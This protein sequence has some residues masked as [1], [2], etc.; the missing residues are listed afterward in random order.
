M[1][2]TVDDLLEAGR[3]A[4][5]RGDWAQARAVLSGAL[6]RQE[7]P[8]ILYYLARAVE[9]S[10][11]YRAAV[12]FYERAFTAYRARGEA[13]MPALIAGRELSFLHAAVYGN[14][15]VAAGWL[16]RA[17]GLAGEA[18]D[19]VERGWVR[20]A[21][22]LVTDDPA[23]KAAHVRDAAE[24]ADR[25][26]DADLRFCALGNQGVT[27]VLA[28]RIT[29]GMRLLDE[30]ATAATSGEVAD[31][32]TAGEIYCHMLTC[33]ELAFD[34]RRAQ[35]WIT[36]GTEFGDRANAPWVSAICRTHY[37]GIL[38]AAGRW[39][40][41][42]RELESSIAQYDASYGALRSSAIVRLADLRV[43]QGRYDEAARLLSGF[44]FD[45]F[46]V[47][48]LARLHLARGEYDSARRI[49][50]RML[51]AAAQHPLQAP[52]L[53]LL[54]E[55]EVA[56]GRLDD[57]RSI[58]RSLAAI[59]QQVEVPMIHALAAYA[60]GITA[61]SAGEPDAAAHLE[62]ALAGFV[63]ADLPLETA[64]A[65]LALSRLLADSAPEIAVAE[66][67]AALT[68]FDTLAATPDAD[69][70]A[71][72]L[73]RLGKPGRPAPRGPGVLTRRETEVLRL[74]AEGLSNEQI[75]Q[76][77][78]LSKR[79][80]EHHVSNILGKLG[81]TTR[82]EATALA[83]RAGSLTASSAEQKAVPPAHGPH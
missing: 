50:S 27:L 11:D 45:S 67:R 64:R 54:A 51:T 66:A 23:E 35:Q 13:R 36:I 14:D 65:R 47:R 16:A 48:P 59:A 71:S 80:V 34:V 15:A 56:A 70:T 41:A 7:S 24:I 57:A 69:A 4:L 28:G 74:L 43:R 21:E 18:G 58:C 37:G 40:D 22:A 77:L 6:E 76:R 79:T 83:V 12:E 20:L 30:A 9:W 3:A 81:V 78:F 17:R 2:Q 62:A 75:A 31:Y 53:A 49:L 25:F 55:V 46:A 19:C 5:A 29:D 61:A 8:E 44:E 42:E 26:G 1:T 52:E 38:T 60:A 82:A 32:L 10:G 72:H 63:A 33:C 39:A 73:R 68:A